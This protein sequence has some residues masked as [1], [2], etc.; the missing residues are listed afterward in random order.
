MSEQIFQETPRNTSSC[1]L[2]KD[3]GET[4]KQREVIKSLIVKT[5]K[6]DAEDYT[7]VE[8]ETTYKITQNYARHPAM[9]L[10]RLKSYKKNMVL[11]A[12]NSFEI[13]HGECQVTSMRLKNDLEESKIKEHVVNAIKTFKGQASFSEDEIKKYKEDNKAKIKQNKKAN[14]QLAKEFRK[15]GLV[16]DNDCM[17]EILANS[18]DKTADKVKV[19]AAEISRC[20]QIIY[21]PKTIEPAKTNYDRLHDKGANV[22][23]LKCYF[24]PQTSSWQVTLEDAT[25]DTVF[26]LYNKT[27]NGLK[28]TW[29]DHEKLQS[30]INKP[31]ITISD[32]Q[33][34]YQHTFTTQQLADLV[35]N[36]DLHIWKIRRD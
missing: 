27:K 13:F 30:V 5:L 10:V 29:K 20:M 23:N 16:V 36:L 4:K 25:E 7:I 28:L 35:K 8:S 3:N 32:N 33:T 17:I 11:Y 12:Y 34:Y 24:R 15:L 18:Y 19:Q 22:L 9:M 6:P 21:A 2:V 31:K 1:V 26:N 14:E